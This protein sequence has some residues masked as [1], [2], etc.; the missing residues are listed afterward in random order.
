MLTCRGA[1]GAITISGS[2]Y[3]HVYAQ[4]GGQIALDYATLR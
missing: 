1:G 3:S 4:N 2:C